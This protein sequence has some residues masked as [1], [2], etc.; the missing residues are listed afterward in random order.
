MAYRTATGVP[1][2]V[3]DSRAEQRVL[4]NRLSGRLVDLLRN[5]GIDHPLRE[6]LT[7]ACV[8]A[9]LYAVA[10]VPAPAWIAAC[11]GN[12]NEADEQ[13]ASL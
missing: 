10:G 5:E 2:H 6:R 12:S 7:L 4:L 8:L 9:D 11:L 3:L 1:L 13:A